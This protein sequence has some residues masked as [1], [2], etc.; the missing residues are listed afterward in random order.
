MVGTYAFRTLVVIGL[1]LIVGLVVHSE[2]RSRDVDQAIHRLWRSLM[3]VIGVVLALVV[4][5]IWQASDAAQRAS[6]AADANCLTLKSSWERAER[7][8]VADVRIAR[9]EYDISVQHLTA[10]QATLNSPPPLPDGSIASEQG[11]LFI[12]DFYANQEASLFREYEATLA[13][14]DALRQELATRENTL[15]DL[16]ADPVGN[17]D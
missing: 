2:W 14:V 6:D 9:A 11:R 7:G 17:C 3:A 1:A 5:G 12:L 10:I 8:L 4:A 16:R 15:D 13:E